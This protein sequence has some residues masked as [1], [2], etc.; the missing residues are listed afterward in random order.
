[1]CKENFKLSFEQYFSDENSLSVIE[2]N[3]SRLTTEENEKHIGPSFVDDIRRDLSSNDTVFYKKN[4]VSIVNG[5]LCIKATNEDNVYYG[6]QAFLKE[7][8]FGNGYLEV[9][10]KLP[11]AIPSVTPKISLKGEKP[12]C[13]FCIDFAQVLGIKGKNE[14]AMNSAF[15]TEGK[16]KKMQMI[17][18]N[19]NTWP[20]LYPPFGSEE[21]LSE[22][23]HTFGFEKDEEFAVFYVDG[24][25]YCKIDLDN[26]VFMVFK[27]ETMLDFSV[28]V[29]LRETEAADENTILPC[30]MLI[31]YVKFYERG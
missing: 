16:Y 18:S 15:L 4:N 7:K 1:M 28:S 25:E 30:E 3:D 20:T 22:D 8:K 21:L 29:G 11:K 26:P 24:N 23:W 19:N 31:E 10:A 12:N 14:C 6:A 5:C 9:K 27:G 17:Y 2:A 13:L